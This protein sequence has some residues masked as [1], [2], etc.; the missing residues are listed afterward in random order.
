MSLEFKMSEKCN[1]C[2]FFRTDPKN[3]VQGGFEIQVMDTATATG[4]SMID[5]P[6][7]L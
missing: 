1:S 2:V 7:P 3:A 4:G 5:L 6:V